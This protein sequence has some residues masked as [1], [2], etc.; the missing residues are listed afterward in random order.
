MLTPA[1][2]PLRFHAQQARLWRSKTRFKA[3]FAGRG[4]G[5]TELARRY[6]VRMLPVRKQWPDPLYF[7]ALPTFAQ[8]KLVAWDKL[9]ALI[10]KHWLRGEPNKSELLINTKFGSQLRVVGLDKPQRVEGVQFD[11]GVIDES[12]DQRPESWSRTLV[13]TFSHRRAWCWRIGVPKRV[14]VGAVAFKEFCDLG[15]SGEDADVETFTWSS[16]DILTEEEL[17]FA[18]ENLDEKDY[19]EQ[20]CASWETATGLIFYAYDDVLNVSETCYDPS[21]PILI[22]SDFNVD[23]MAWV[24]AQKRGTDLH[25]IDELFIRNT[26]TQATLNA[27]FQKYGHHAH[28]FHFFGD[29]SSKARKTAATA[30]DYIQI[31]SDSRFVGSRVYYPDS[32]PA[33]ADRFAS[34]NAMMCNAAGERRV[35]I[36]PRCKNLRDDLMRRAYVP[37]C[38]EPDDHGDVGHITDA[39]GYLV[40]TLF[41]IRLHFQSRGSA[42]IA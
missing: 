13:P 40:H 35:K 1:W 10:P 11:G 3:V 4:S 2:Y 24:V 18:R 30:S 42:V 9:C 22:G 17:R 32:N 14:G 15:A 37:G 7:Y 39:L 25:V 23:P 27:L 26:N 16:E 33:V 34:T 31:K 41:P 28:G 36:H 6:V 29:A 38:N 5:K 8:A 12:C 20:Y 21:L 19:N